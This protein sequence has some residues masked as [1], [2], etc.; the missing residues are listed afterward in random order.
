[1]V[2]LI[3]IGVCVVA[4]SLMAWGISTFDEAVARGKERQRARR[5]EIR[6]SMRPPQ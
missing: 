6:K 1:V 2:L 4:L 3:L 5:R